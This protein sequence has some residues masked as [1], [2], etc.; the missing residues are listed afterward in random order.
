[1]ARTLR[2][3]YDGAFYHIR[4]KGYLK[5]PIFRD[6]EDYQYFLNALGE[7]CSMTGWRVHAWVLLPDHYH[8]FIEAPFANLV[9]GMQWLQNAFTRRFA[10]RY[11]NEG[12]LF[13]DRYKAIP[14]EGRDAFFYRTL[15]DYLHLNP[16]RAGLINPAT[17]QSIADFRWSSVAGGFLL[18]PDTR[19]VGFVGEVGMRNLGFADDVEGREEWIRGLDERARTE[20]RERCGVPPV[21]PE[22]DR[23]RSTIRRGWFW[24]SSMFS[25]KLQRIGEWASKAH[26]NLGSASVRKSGTHGENRALRILEQ[27]LEE[28][29][30]TQENLAQLRGSDPRKVR[31]AVRIK[32]ETIVSTQWIATNLRMKSAA[33]ASHQIRQYKRAVA[34]NAAQEV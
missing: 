25:E 15:S 22:G 26:R 6:A 10:V 31:I 23:R 16:V 34:C 27:G 21:E 4:V 29:G 28:A 1:M 18:P 5:R 30:L 33:N 14:V 3:E 13:A 32:R 12:K 2:V 19:P 17:G 11:L 8:L 24:G 9:A 20:P 7:A